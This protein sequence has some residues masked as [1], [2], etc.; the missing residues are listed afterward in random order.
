MLPSATEERHGSGRL[1]QIGKARLPI[2]E[3]VEGQDDEKELE[4]KMIPVRKY[5]YGVFGVLLAIVCRGGGAGDDS[6]ARRA[7]EAMEK[8]TRFFVTKVATH[9]GYLWW[10]SED[11]KERAGE[12]KATE[13]QIWVQPPGTPSV[14]FAFLRAYRVTGSEIYLDAAKRAADALVWGQLACGGWDYKIDFDPE[15][16]KRWH[17]RRDNGKHKPGRGARY[18]AVFDDNTTQSAL[19]FLMAVDGATNRQP[20]YHEA[21]KYGL[22]FMLSSQFPNGAWSQ[23]YPPPHSRG[24]WDYYTFND[25]A[26]NDCISV[27]LDA[28]KGYGDRRYLESAKK[29]GDFIIASQLPAPQAGWAQQYDHDM[30]PAAARWFEPA[31]CCSAVTCRNIRTLIGLY[32]ETGEEKYLKPIPASLEWLE[33]SKLRDNVWARFYE[34]RTNRPI[35]VT[36]EREIVYE[37]VN[38][39]QGYG[40]SG[41]YGGDE[42]ARLYKSVIALGRERYLAEK[43]RAP[44]PGEAER[45]LRSLEARVKKII[46]AQDGEGRW[47]ESGRIE[48]STFIRNMGTLCDYLETVR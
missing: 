4:G 48:T 34:L 1:R 6:L 24:Y 11:L 27:M 9:G 14:G 21:V 12:G 31:A 19:R 22:E 17:Y 44:S 35:Y 10:Y 47:V 42:V 2:D 13:T 15:G 25:N 38:L 26:I 39:R 18:F 7:S 5:C 33:R 23:A 40:W 37:P 41:D 36:A 29:G 45:R 30:K 46:A 16:S 8:A 3:L 20:E 28:Y 43:E 32:L